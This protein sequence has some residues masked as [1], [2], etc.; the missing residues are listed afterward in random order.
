MEVYFEE[1]FGPIACV[2]E[3]SG[4]EE[5]VLL[6]NDTKYGLGASIWTK[7]SDKALLLQSLL[8]C[9]MVA[10]NKEVAS[11]PELPFGGIKSSGHGRE[12][13]VEGIKSFCNCKTVVVA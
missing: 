10:V 5:A 11:Y 6:A 13:S 3:V 8:D 7:D 12:L 1:V 9:G 4:E 2:F